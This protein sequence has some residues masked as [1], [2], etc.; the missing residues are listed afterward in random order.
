MIGPA[1]SW[2]FLWDYVALIGVIFGAA[3]LIWLFK[4]HGIKVAMGA[5]MV[6]AFMALSSMVYLSPFESMSTWILI[7]T[8]GRSIEMLA[9]WTVAAERLRQ[10]VVTIK[11]RPQQAEEAVAAPARQSNERSESMRSHH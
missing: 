11:A 5:A 8:I 4:S 3:I 6:E 7:K 1:V 2:M 9:F 10:S